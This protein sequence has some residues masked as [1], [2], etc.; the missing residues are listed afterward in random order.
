MHDNCVKFCFFFYSKGSKKDIWIAVDPKTGIKL[1]TV[2]MDGTQK[3][4]PSTN[5]NIIYIGRT[6]KN[7]FFS[8]RTNTHF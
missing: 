4:C 1:H 2:T 5:D 3:V 8:T 7:Y 6:G